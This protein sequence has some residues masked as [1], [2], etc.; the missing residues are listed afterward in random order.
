MFHIPS[1]THGVHTPSHLASSSSTC[2]PPR[3]G[4]RNLAATRIADQ[5]AF[6]LVTMASRI[7]AEAISSLSPSA[8]GYKG[9]RALEHYL[10]CL[11]LVLRKQL[12]WLIGTK[13]L[14]EELETL[15]RDLWALKLQS[16][17]PRFSHD[18]DTETDTQSYYFSSQSEGEA[19]ASEAS[20]RSRRRRSRVKVD[21][22][23]N[24]MDTLALCYMGMLLLREPVTV[25]DIHRWASE[26][27]LLYYCASKE[28]PLG[29]RERLSPTLQELL[30]ARPLGT[31]EK[32]Q[33]HVQSM[34]AQYS[35][36]LGMALPPVNHPLLLYD[37]TR[38]LALPIEVFAATTRLA[39]MLDVTFEFKLDV[40]P[41]TKDV[42][43]RYPEARLMALLVVATKL[44]FP[45]DD[46]QRS[47]TSVTAMDALAMDWSTWAPTQFPS[48]PYGGTKPL[49]YA[50]ALDFTQ[51]DV[52]GASERQLDQYMDWCE[53][54]IANEDVRTRGKAG[55]D[56]DFRRTLLSM[57]PAGRSMT[58]LDGN[59][60]YPEGM[61]DVP[62]EQLRA[63]QLAL[64]PRQSAELPHHGQADVAGIG[65]LYRRVRSV[66]ELD[67]HCR[68]FYER[69]ASLAGLS[70]DDMVRAVSL[71][72]IQVQKREVN[73]RKGVPG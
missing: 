60:L 52:L 6:G 9:S 73:L 70:L 33:K 71:M 24:L 1:S 37:W 34:L 53:A 18:S 59:E 8:S 19:S 45:F 13:K 40:K 38:A 7:A 51:M 64:T 4:D 23:P 62:T 3:E 56:A 31:A 42:M 35:A 57:F 63:V 16:L 10:L 44:L 25:A 2:P 21:G 54:N 30:E 22:T 11:Q 61:E 14:P 43:L 48:G 41:R 65:S 68:M 17:R 66:E 72:E 46:V 26:G 47:A 5:D 32:L 69:A 58:A 49:P 67:G 28:V 12:R 36:D 29:M 15:V 50:A 39:R 55:R 20:A 27:D